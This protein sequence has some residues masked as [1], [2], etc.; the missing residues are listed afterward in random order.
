[1]FVSSAVSEKG[2]KKNNLQEVL[3]KFLPV[4]NA[5][6][7]NTSQLLKNQGSNRLLTSDHLA[8]VNLLH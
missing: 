7:S 2:N 3:T 8:K 6:H 5:A 1:M 4:L